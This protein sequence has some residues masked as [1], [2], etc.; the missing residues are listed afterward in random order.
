M[1]DA[2]QLW[3]SFVT[4][5][6]DDSQ[7]L[8]ESI[9][10]LIG[11][12]LGRDSLPE[13]A[14]ISFSLASQ[15]LL[16]GAEK[17]GN[18]AAAIE[19]CLGLLYDGQ[20]DPAQAL[21]LLASGI[22]TVDKAFAE[23][24]TADKSGARIE[25][26]PLEAATYELETLFPIP[27]KPA[28]TPTRP[29]AGGPDVPLSRL[30][31]SPKPSDIGHDETPVDN[32]PG[33]GKVSWHP[34]LGD[35]MIELFFLEVDDR[36][37]T[38][39]VKLLEIEQRPND[40]ELLRDVF[41]DWHTIK[42]SS[43]MVSLDPMTKLAH[44]AEDLVGQLREGQRS[45]TGPVIDALL[46]ALDALREI[47]SQAQHNRVIDLVLEPLYERLR[48][49]EAQSMANIVGR[50]SPPLDAPAG[51]SSAPSPR[52]SNRQTIRVDFDKLDSL[53]NLVGEL[54][55]GRD[56]LSTAVSALSALSGE[57]AGEQQLTKILRN[58]ERNESDQLGL[59]T[60]ELGR[61]E[62]VLVDIFQELDTSS[63]RLDSISA[64]L[65]DSVMGLRMVPVAGTL[66]K[67]HRTV[68]DLAN[69]LG[70]QVTLQ[71][72]GED[73]E[74]DKLLVEAVDEPLM[75][76]VRNAVDHGI[77]SPA[78]RK[79]AGKP[80]EGT[81]VLSATHTGNQ[82]II[83]IRDDG[84]GIDP[85]RI[86]ARALERQLVTAEAAA[87]M[88]SK[89]VLELIFHAGFSTAEVVSEVSGRGVGMDV[90]RQTIINQLKGTIDIDS[91]L[92][93]G[94]R[95]TLRLPLTLA[96]AQVLLARAGG[97]TLAIPLDAVARTLVL[98]STAIQLIQDREFIAVKG[99]QV[100][101][102]RIARV[103]GLDCGHEGVA[104]EL[105]VVL[106]EHGNGLYALAVE[107]LIKK[108]EII[109]KSL[110]DILET[111]PCAGGATL[112]GDRCAVILDVA[113]VIR[114]AVQGITCASA[115]TGVH[116]PLAQGT[117]REGDGA[118]A[119][120]HAASVLLVEDSEVVREALRR[121]LTQAGYRVVVAHDGVE[122]LAAAQK[123]KFDLISTDVMMPRMDGYELT[124]A[125]RKTD[126]YRDAPI[127][128][129]T[130][131]GERIDR[132][133]GFDAGV[134]EYITKPHDRHILVRTV[135]RLLGDTR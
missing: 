33:G 108:K 20:V 125:L 1:T 9:A 12:E 97:E 94:S 83:E 126:E 13:L 133:R 78:E 6:R 52:V 34:D 31:R 41:R 43:A 28:D 96:I 109:I 119:E 84:G 73:T 123:E 130:S 24:E 7:L 120:A 104:R 37:E 63:G 25:N 3:D 14:Y 64:D 82:V 26:T 76:L 89:E 74:L 18:L 16:L 132:V 62:R 111:V 134:D 19:R 95:F 5:G 15:A 57:L 113:A 17:L 116:P 51:E 40:I 8:V 2:V 92:G 112:I 70:K 72:R 45:A 85:E 86:R 77:E 65:R 59:L 114:R 103:L 42:G 87:V 107:A 69:S 32:A 93:K 60:E 30:V 102:I 80:P 38:I 36:I 121:L 129:V 44:A 23:F 101:L 55:L 88:T 56:S 68:R 39:S 50:P 67:H 98:P 135:K 99:Q 29:H 118:K 66:R 124:R 11:E 46:A 127:L 122:G 49:P 47:A 48:Q 58:A 53:M 115:P 100:P 90:V 71:L 21:P 105:R 131:R 75:H 128:M 61:V 117:D 79:L 22:E 106:C 110:G 27:G 35:D 91:K 54:V 4:R 81:I 10:K